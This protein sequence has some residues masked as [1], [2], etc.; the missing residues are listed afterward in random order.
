MIE[1]FRPKS[2]TVNF[3]LVDG[4]V[5]DHV[6][7]FT[8]LDYIARKYPWITQLVWMPD[9]LLDLAKNLIRYDHVELRS[10][11]EMRGRY[12]PSKPTKSTKWDGNTS[13][14]KIHCLDYAFLKLCDEN[15]DL[16][17]K[18][19]LPLRRGEIDISKFVLPRS[20]VV[21][22]TGFTAAVREFRPEI[23]N[24]IASHFQKKT[25]YEVVFL[26]N[27]DG[28]TGSAHTIKAKFKDEID[29]TNGI[30]LIDKTTLLEA[31]AVMH[32]AKAVLGVDNG[33]LHVA[34]CTPADIIGGFTTVS[35][36]IRMPV[37]GDVMGRGFY[38]IAPYHS[39]QCR[40]CQQTTNFIYGHKYTD[41]L[42]KETEAENE[43][44]KQLSASDFIYGM[45]Y[46][47][48]IKPLQEYGVA[49]LRSPSDKLS[50]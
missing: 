3:L 45:N 29:F 50:E 38:P 34:G 16:S 47:N 20:Y 27:T 26:G 8:A 33:L 31:A 48:Q 6:A 41:C 18:N 14:M 21:L 25:D 5:G 43:C 17:E 13:P 9:L 35:P 49:A 32:D 1:G 15:P 30:N 46:L 12:D 10:F 2:R 19:Y 7:S 22:T 24:E 37:R 42:F 4:G 11:T 23:V 28:K 44:T 40:F 36:W 39:L